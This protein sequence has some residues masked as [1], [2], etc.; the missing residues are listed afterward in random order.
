MMRIGFDA[1]RAFCN[2]TGLGNYS[3][4][5][6][7][8]YHRHYPA[9]ELV[10]YSPAGPVPFA[11]EPAA[12]VRVRRPRNWLGR[13]CPPLWRSFGVAGDIAVDELDIFHGLSHE[14]PFRALPHRTRTVVTIHDLIHVRYPRQYPWFDRQ[15]YERKFRFACRRA[16]RVIAVS[17]QTRQDIV[18]FFGTPAEKIDVVYQSCD[19]QFFRE[20]DAN[21]ADARTLARNNIEGAYFLYVGSLIERKNAL[22]IVEAFREFPARDHYRLVLVGQGGAYRQRVVDAV[23]RAGLSDRVVMIPRGDFADLPALYRQ[24]AAL[25]Y[26][27]FFEGFGIPIIEALCSGTPV[28]TSE[29]GCFAEAGGGGALYVHP[30]SPAAIRD[31]MSRL[32]DD[33]QLYADLVAQGRE[34]VQRFRPG[35]TAARL[36]EVYRG[37][38][39]DK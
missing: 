25:V 31:A 13:V 7:Q 19:E 20:V 21:D 6:I 33:R 34:H 27:S 18:E 17:E 29:G 10:L 23:A 3:R 15:V 14:I 24:A 9:D 35:V 30:R 28:I 2:R 8:N 32:A 22:G 36:R 38:V 39:A 26:P 1:K 5:L 16:D 12:N 11:P 37:L 4:T